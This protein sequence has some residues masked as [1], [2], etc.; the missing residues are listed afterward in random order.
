MWKLTVV[1]VAPVQKLLVRCYQK[2]P[3]H[4][5]RDF[6]SAGNR[7]CR[8]RDGITLPPHDPYKY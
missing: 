3:V 2:T 1:L 4:Q 8:Q 7:A 6:A 5:S